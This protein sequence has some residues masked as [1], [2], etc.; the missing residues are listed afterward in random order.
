MQRVPLGRSIVV[1][2]SAAEEVSAV[3]SAIADFAG[4]DL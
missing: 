2:E 1:S 3:D 4:A